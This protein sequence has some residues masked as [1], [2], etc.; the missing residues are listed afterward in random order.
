MN[1]KIKK[2]SNQS[3]IDNPCPHEKKS[4]LLVDEILGLLDMWTDKFVEVLLRTTCITYRLIPTLSMTNS[5]PTGVWR[6]ELWLVCDAQKHF[7][8]LKITI[9]ISEKVG[10]AHTES[11]SSFRDD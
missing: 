10:E 2:N 11:D 1:G 3:F 4:D 7:V 8:V 6:L 5:L 9:N